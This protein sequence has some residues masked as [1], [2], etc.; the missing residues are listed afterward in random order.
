VVVHTY[1]LSIWEVETGGLAGHGH[2]WIYEYEDI[3]IYE[4]LS[5]K[6][7]T[8]TKTKKKKKEKGTK[9]NMDQIVLAH[10]FSPST[11]QA[12]EGRSLSSIP[13]LSTE[14]VPT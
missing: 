3:L 14:R 4:A 5:Q 13:A 8:K 7:K 1:N 9:I 10:T 2:S 6:S 12:E 11:Q